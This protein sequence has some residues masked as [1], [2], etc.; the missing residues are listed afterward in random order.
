MEADRLIDYLLAKPGAYL[1]FP[2]D[3]V[4]ATV[5]L[6][7][8]RMDKGPIILML[9]PIH[10]VESAT[11]RCEPE[12]GSAWKQRHPGVIQRGWHSPPT[13]QPYSITFPMESPLEDDEVLE[14]ADEA[15][16]SVLG[17]LPK[18]R[19]QELAELRADFGTAQQDEQPTG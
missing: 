15:Y 14:M 9:C 1:D 6:K 19:Q 8:P 11:L 17:R 10:G 12:D 16:A 3:D 2:F 13:Q 18:Y 5:R 4:T 7:S